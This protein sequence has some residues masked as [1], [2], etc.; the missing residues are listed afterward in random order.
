MK[1]ILLTL[2]CAVPLAILVLFFYYVTCFMAQPEDNFFEP[3]LGAAGFALV[4][5]IMVGLIA[6]HWNQEI[7]AL[8]FVLI[9]SMALYAIANW[10]NNVQLEV[11]NIVVGCGAKLP[12]LAT[13]SWGW[14]GQLLLSAILM[15]LAWLI[16]SKKEKNVSGE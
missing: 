15:G 8:V 12:A 14:I 3:F 6:R 2:L 11:Y 4:Y 5:T 9:V 7:I 16:V 13:T 10:R 1:Q